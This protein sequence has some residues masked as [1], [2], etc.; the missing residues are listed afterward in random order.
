[1]EKNGSR[2]CPACG[3]SDYAFR[4]RK[5][6]EAD[7]DKGEPEAW[8]TKYRCK[9]CAHEWREKIQVKGATDAR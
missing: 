9:N 6:I 2:V 3:S 8:E 1:M 7:P 5:K 4:M